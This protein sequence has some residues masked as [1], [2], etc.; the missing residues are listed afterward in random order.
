MPQLPHGTSPT[1]SAV[2]F[3]SS[4]EGAE[5]TSTMP[6]TPQLRS[7]IVASSVCPSL[8]LSSLS[9]R[10]RAH[11]CRRA[12]AP[13]RVREIFW[14]CAGIQGQVR[15]GGRLRACPIRRVPGQVLSGGAARRDGENA[16][17][18]N[19]QR[20]SSE[21]GR[22][23]AARRGRSFAPGRGR[24]SRGAPGWRGRTGSGERHV[25]DPSKGF[26]ARR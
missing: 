22:P 14:D 18:I 23:E 4:S 25:G 15:R 10:V 17:Y 11:A 12:R 13:T 16:R 19:R 26:R 9:H 3:A 8:T 2:T 1:R 6:Q 5:I 24:E 21:R 7:R 20:A